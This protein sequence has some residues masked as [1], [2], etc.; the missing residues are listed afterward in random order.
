MTHQLRFCISVLCYFKEGKKVL[1]IVT[2]Y[3]ATLTGTAL[4]T[5]VTLKDMDFDYGTFK[6]VSPKI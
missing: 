3:L 2:G 6:L 4:S 1:F 5:E